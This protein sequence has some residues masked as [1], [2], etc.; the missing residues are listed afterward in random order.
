MTFE[1]SKK[2]FEFQLRMADKVPTYF[3]RDEDL[4]D[5]QQETLEGM[6]GFVLNTTSVEG[7][8]I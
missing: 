4:V 3:V 5:N 1:F 2:M 6:F 8:N 7:K